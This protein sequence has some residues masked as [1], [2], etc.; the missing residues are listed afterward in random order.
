M[1]RI[2]EEGARQMIEQLSKSK[3]YI[4]FLPAVA[5]MEE[6][7]RFREGFLHTG[8]EFVSIQTTAGNKVQIFEVTE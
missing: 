2:I 6:V 1:V 8:I 3:K 5:S 4:L 7:N